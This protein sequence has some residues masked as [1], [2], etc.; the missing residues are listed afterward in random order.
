MSD[1]F[2]NGQDDVILL[3]KVVGD[4]P[5]PALH[6]HVDPR[7]LR[8]VRTGAT[9]LSVGAG[10]R[11]NIGTAAVGHNIPLRLAEIRAVGDGDQDGGAGGSGQQ[12]DPAVVRGLLTHTLQGA[13][14]L[15]ITHYTL[16]ITYYKLP[17]REHSQG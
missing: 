5:L 12:G 13:H 10:A 16:H 4:V 6:L 8:S 7:H 1:E 3:V 17:L 9:V 11:T 2:N 14:T 15:H